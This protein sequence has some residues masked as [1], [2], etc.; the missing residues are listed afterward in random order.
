[1]YLVL[2]FIIVIFLKIFECILFCIVEFLWEGE[3]LYNV[4]CWIL[5]IFKVIWCKGCIVSEIFKILE[6]SS[7]NEFVFVGVIFEFIDVI[8][9]CWGVINGMVIVDFKFDEKGVV[10][11]MCW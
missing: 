3:C 4:V 9:D 7:C 1:M 6:V 2:L 8:I 5:V 11:V 10:F